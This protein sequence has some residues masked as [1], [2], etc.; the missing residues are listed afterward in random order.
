MSRGNNCTNP[1]SSDVPLKYYILVNCEPIEIKEGY[2]LVTKNKVDNTLN[3]IPYTT[4][5]I[6]KDNGDYVKGFNSSSHK[7]EF[8]L[9]KGGRKSRSIRIF[10]EKRKKTRS[11]K[12]RK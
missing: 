10:R 9:N 7:I 12:N 3:N 5:E 8:D 1:D 4:F 6:S 2:K 11:M